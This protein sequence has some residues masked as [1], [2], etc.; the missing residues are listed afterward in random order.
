MLM[1]SLFL[2]LAVPIQVYRAVP[3]KQQAFTCGSRVRAAASSHV[4]ATDCRLMGPTPGSSS[5]Q[6][7]GIL[8]DDHATASLVSFAKGSAQGVLMPA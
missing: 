3:P 4:R 5:A 6:E 1:H 8:A 2:L 7:Y